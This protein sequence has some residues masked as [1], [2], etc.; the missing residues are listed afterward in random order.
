MELCTSSVSSVVVMPPPFVRAT[1]CESASTNCVP[2]SG[3]TIGSPGFEGSG[4]V[5]SSVRSGVGA[6]AARA[7]TDED[8]NER[9]RARRRVRTEQSDS[10][11]A[12]PRWSRRCTGR[13][14]RA[15]AVH[16]WARAYADRLGAAFLRNARI[17]FRART[18]RRS[19]TAP[20]PSR[21]RRADPHGAVG[22]C[23]SNAIRRSRRSCRRGSR[24]SRA[25]RTC[26]AR[27]AAPRSRR[28]RLR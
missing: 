22:A 27:S 16:R 11:R 28:C 24:S 2:G 1:K 6:P 4:Q 18:D 21:S 14:P 7:A 12:C 8:Q 17:G 25:R 19:S 10:K 15:G 23:R 5:R 3:S 20:A 9:Q 13:T 26:R